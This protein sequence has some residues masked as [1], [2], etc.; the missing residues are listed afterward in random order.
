MGPP[1]GKIHVL[2]RGIR[3]M[4]STF[5]HIRLQLNGRRHV[6]S[7]LAAL[8]AIASLGLTPSS[9]G[10]RGEPSPRGL[11]LVSFEPGSAGATQ[12]PSSSVSYDDPVRGDGTRSQ[13]R[14]TLT[15]AAGEVFR[16]SLV[17]TQGDVQGQGIERGSCKGEPQGFKVGLVTNPGS[18]FIDGI[19][20]ACATLDTAFRGSRTI[21]NTVQVCEELAISLRGLQPGN[22]PPPT[23][24]CTITSDDSVING[25]PGDD[26]ICVG[27][28]PFHEVFVG[29]GDDIVRG[30]AGRDIIH[31]GPGD[32]RL[33][34]GFGGNDTIIG[35]PGDDECTQKGEGDTDCETI[36]R[37]GELAPGVELERVEDDAL[38]GETDPE[39]GHGELLLP[40]GTPVE[41]GDI[42]NS[43]PT[44]ALPLGFLGRVISLTPTSNGVL[45]TTEAVAL[46]D[47]VPYGEMDLRF[48]GETPVSDE[49]P[50]PRSAPD[51][52]RGSSSSGPQ[53]S[54]DFSA[55]AG[56]I[57]RSLG[58]EA[59]ATAEVSIDPL[60]THSIDAG[61]AWV[62]FFDP[63]AYFNGAVEVGADASFSASAGVVCDASA[64][65][66]G[67]LLGT[68]V[69]QVGPVTVVFTL[70]S[71]VDL[72]FEAS[73][74]AAV[75]VD[76]TVKGGVQMLA[77]LVDGNF[78]HG[79][80]PT[81]EASLEAEVLGEVEAR[82][83]ASASISLEA[84]GAA[85]PAVSFGPFV[86]ATARPF[87]DPWLVVD[88]GVRAG[89]DFV[90]DIWR[91]HERYTVAE[92]D[93]VRFSIERRRGTFP[94]PVIT[95]TELSATQGEAFEVQLEAQG[96]TAPLIWSAEDGSLPEGVKLGPSGVVS[97]T[98]TEAGTTTARVIV[99]DADGRF[100]DGALGITVHPND[101]GEEDPG[102]G[103][104]VIWTRDLSGSP[105]W[106]APTPDGRL[107]L[108]R[109]NPN[110]GESIGSSGNTEFVIPSFVYTP[111]S[112][113]SGNSYWPVNNAGGERLQKHDPAG[114]LLWSQP[115]A[116]ADM[117]GPVH[118]WETVVGADDAAWVLVNHTLVRFDP[119]TGARTEFS[120]PFG[121]VFVTDDAIVVYRAQS[122]RNVIVARVTYNGV[123]E[124]FD[125]GPSLFNQ[126]IRVSE[127]NRHGEMFFFD[128]PGCFAAP[129]LGNAPI[130][131]KMSSDGNEM[132]RYTFPPGRCD[133]PQLEPLSDGGVAVVRQSE[134]TAFTASGEVA[135]SPDSQY[136]AYVAP[137]VGDDAGHLI[138]SAH[139]LG[140]DPA[141]VRVHDV[142][143]GSSVVIASFHSGGDVSVSVQQLVVGID[144]VWV[145]VLERRNGR[146]EYSIA[147]V[148]AP[149]VRPRGSTA[150]SW[151]AAEPVS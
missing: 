56:G 124:E 63:A 9:G 40:V 33:T 59:S 130:L 11:E 128:T 60:I 41:V 32:D 66:N 98:P 81:H 115:I 54:G 25:T 101:T 86:E 112:D 49:E 47:I 131:R 95:T 132:W 31:G 100:Q 110:D 7:L 43:G 4:A 45:A 108:Q 118:V 105:G 75:E 117:D 61:A 5:A 1:L 68:Q 24:E 16:L 97:G 30:G 83:D 145:S 144:R 149:G 116:D 140:N 39:T 119:W 28:G 76:G 141:V 111:V 74:R 107:L 136:S 99:Q 69:V 18:T 142:V 46:P 22:P 52:A 127:F 135:W 27:D 104:G 77:S 134:L 129:D 148:A 64:H 79:L 137:V 139:P 65:I 37:E 125:V 109:P 138:A 94:G 3:A 38:G 6:L 48:E 106:M 36:H 51:E 29:A 71:G 85:G 92:A 67:P 35:G 91:I 78:S 90:F 2:R 12:S 55:N 42:V 89:V 151:S 8:L 87:E 19:S 58:C 123:V 13:V 103:D 96:G 147:S 126:G 88:G 82:F 120:T 17:L 84:Y 10:S 150:S 93:L 114:V 80:F 62:P 146:D 143:D 34:G 26:V 15:C 102:T 73:T 20:E 23:S 113:R 44:E 53:A 133:Y 121:D 122:G 70:E 72:G 21:A 14:G 50:P 57:T